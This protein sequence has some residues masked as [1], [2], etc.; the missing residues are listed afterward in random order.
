[1]AIDYHCCSFTI[2]YR[3]TTANTVI[4]ILTT[5]KGKL[6]APIRKASLQFPVDFLF[7]IC[8]F[9]FEKMT[10]NRGILPAVKLKIENRK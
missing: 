5:V 6:F 4:P 10:G 8:Y 1:M 7:L 3:Q 9:L 2:L